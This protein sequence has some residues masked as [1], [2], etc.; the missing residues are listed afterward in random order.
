[1]SRRL[2]A[3]R[4]QPLGFRHLG[5]AWVTTFVSRMTHFMGL[6]IGMMTGMGREANPGG[7]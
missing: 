5:M 1:M 2:M 4:L 3:P 7:D 6:L